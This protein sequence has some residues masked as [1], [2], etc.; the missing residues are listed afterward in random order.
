M[1][2]RTESG[3]A[4]SPDSGRIAFSAKRE[5]FDEPQ[6]YV[7][8]IAG[9]GEAERVTAVST[10]ATRPEWRPDGGAILFT[11]QTW[12]GALTDAD[13]RARSEERKARKYN[14]RVFEQFPVRHWDRWLDERRPTL[15]LQ[16]LGDG[17][18]G[19]GYHQVAGRVEVRHVGLEP[20]HLPLHPRFE[21]GHL[22]EVALSHQMQD[23]H[24]GPLP[25]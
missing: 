6:I 17:S 12:P 7:L 15:M 24:V 8:D 22:I 23:L 1:K 18:A 9:G 21:R 11:S 4:W 3:A 20:H 10:G 2:P 5:G 16:G 13:N 14:A 19:P 25:R